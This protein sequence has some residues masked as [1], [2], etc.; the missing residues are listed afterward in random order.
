MDKLIKI[1]DYIYT[2]YDKNHSGS[3]EV[4]ELDDLMK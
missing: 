1:C 3:L 2:K 4:K